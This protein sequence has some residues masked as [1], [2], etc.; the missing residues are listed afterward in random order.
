MYIFGTFVFLV[1]SF[2]P[3][4]NLW[5]YFATF[6]MFVVFVS[7]MNEFYGRVN[8]LNGNHQWWYRWKEVSLQLSQ[9]S[10]EWL[11][12]SPRWSL[13]LSST[14]EMFLRFLEAQSQV[15]KSISASHWLKQ[16]FV[17]NNMLN[18]AVASLYNLSLWTFLANVF[19]LRV[20]ID[21]DAREKADA[22]RNSLMMNSAVEKG[23]L[24]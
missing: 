2:V 6:D 16:L 9:H 13:I 24:G 20:N 8:T 18:V 4:V 14:N 10:S 15:L 12:T 11:I 5:H 23:S 22:Q 7:R 1:Y 17:Y 3:R 21:T 19:L